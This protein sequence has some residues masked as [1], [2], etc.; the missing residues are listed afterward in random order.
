MTV[1]FDVM[2]D[3]SNYEGTRLNSL[4][5]KRIPEERQH[6]TGLGGRIYDDG[7]DRRLR[8]LCGYFLGESC[9]SE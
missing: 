4:F 1:N 5:L 6:Y 3:V 2:L 9:H 7:R 8:L